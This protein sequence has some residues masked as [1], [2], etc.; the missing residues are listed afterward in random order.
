MEREAF[1]KLVDE[2]VDSLPA[3]F[4]K[5]IHNVAVIVEDEPAQETR[6]RLSA[7]HRGE[8]LGLY[9]G[10]PYQHRGP[11]YGNHPP[12][13]IVIYQK[14]IERI[15]STDD[16]V[17]EQVKATVIHEVGHYFGFSDPELREI[18]RESRPRN[19]PRLA[20]RER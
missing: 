18:E 12:D 11:Y 7:P 9:H 14:P 16:E 10:V 2:A 1:E 5:L 6:R 20:P 3:K 4:K 8:I 13:V 19:R 15:C 17:R